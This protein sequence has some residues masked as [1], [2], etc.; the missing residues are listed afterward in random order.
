MEVSLSIVFWVWLGVQAT[1]VIDT[2]ARG[3]SYN[4][5]KTCAFT[6]DKSQ[7]IHEDVESYKRN[8]RI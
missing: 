1:I 5:N 8:I 2:Y 3:P 6:F 4:I 7:S